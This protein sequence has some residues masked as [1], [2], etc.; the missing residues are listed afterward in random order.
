MIHVYQNH[1]NTRTSRPCHGLVCFRTLILMT[2][3]KTPDL[4]CFNSA[5]TPYNMFTPSP[6]LDP[7]PVSISLRVPLLTCGLIVIC[8]YREALSIYDYD[9]ATK[10]TGIRPSSANGCNH[11]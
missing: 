7:G 5:D 9:R 10:R 2:S 3:V 8:C 11:P 4:A 1:D 6:R